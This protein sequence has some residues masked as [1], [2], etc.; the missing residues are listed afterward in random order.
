MQ[1]IKICQITLQ[2][3]LHPKGKTS[4]LSPKAFLQIL[5]TVEGGIV[6]QMFLHF[7]ALCEACGRCDEGGCVALLTSIALE[8][9]P[10]LM[11]CHFHQC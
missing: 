10:E 2:V 1:S 5:P 3:L 6:V 4:C 8:R 9:Y 11:W 7:L